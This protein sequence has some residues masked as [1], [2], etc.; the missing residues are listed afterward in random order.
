MPAGMILEYGNPFVPGKAIAIAPDGNIVVAGTSQNSGGDFDYEI[1]KY[2]ANGDEAWE[3]RYGS[4]NQGNDQ[5]RAMTIDP[6]GNVIVTGTSDTVKINQAGSIVWSAPV[7]GRALIANASYVYVTGFS[8]VDISTAQLENNNVDGRELWRNFIDGRNQGTDFSHAITLDADGNIY[9]AGQEEYDP[10]SKIGICWRLFAVVS[11]SPAGTQR[12]FGEARTSTFPSSIAYANSITIQSDRSVQVFGSYSMT[13]YLASFDS[14]GTNV[15]SQ[16][17]AAQYG[18]KMITDSTGNRFVAGMDNNANAF[19]ASVNDASHQLQPLWTY[20]G[21]GQGTVGMDLAQDWHSNI[22]VAGYLWNQDA[23]LSLFLAKV[24]ATGRQLGL[25]RFNSP[26]AG[27]NFATSLAIDANDNVYVTGYVQNT[28]GG[29]EIVTIK[30]SA[31]PKIDRKADAMH[32]EF[33]TSPGQRYS[34]EAS[35]DFFN[36][37]G[38]ITNTADVN[39]L[40]QFDDTN[41]TSVPFR[42]YRGNSAP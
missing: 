6:S 17:G 31:A 42:F 37:R 10:C 36:W 29:S 14:N 35:G 30:Y 2:K 15:W 26:N 3:V 32:L 27:N 13:A 38:L 40:I 4:A 22:H 5:L 39:G 11:Y 24:S 33:H 41:T 1:I 20:G 18:S 28:Q 16:W 19:L 9:V 21:V 8:D 23:S 34:I 12:W 7:G 25:D